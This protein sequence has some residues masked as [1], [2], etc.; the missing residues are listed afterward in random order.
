MHLGRHLHSALSAAIAATEG[1]GYRRRPSNGVT[2]CP[3]KL[4]YSR[5]GAEAAPRSGRIGLIFDDG[6]YTES[7]TLML[8]EKSGIKVVPLSSQRQASIPECQMTGHIDAVAETPDGVQFLFEHKNINCY[9]FEKFESGREWPED[10][11]YQTIAYMHGL[12]LKNG[13]LFIRNKNTGAYLEYW[14]EISLGGAICTEA[15]TTRNGED[16]VAPMAI[17]EV[18]I[19]EVIGRYNALHEEAEGMIVPARKYQLGKDW[20]CGYC[21]YA[22]PC[23]GD[24]IPE[25]GEEV[26]CPKDLLPAFRKYENSRI[27]RLAAAKTA[28]DLEP[29]E[30]EYKKAVLEYMEKNKVRYFIREKTVY[31]IAAKPVDTDSGQTVNAPNLKTISLI[32]WR[33]N[34][35]EKYLNPA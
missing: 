26:E 32:T 21:Q 28:K 12:D 4:W 16:G 6:H 20:Q 15:Y 9:T 2:T 27:A 8:M 10:Y 25:A 19:S 23:W 11:V 5:Q 34:G 1:Q 31:Y 24:A 18:R 30:A 35:P 14:F 7:Q 33:K 13:C 29:E 3:R 17:P 22:G